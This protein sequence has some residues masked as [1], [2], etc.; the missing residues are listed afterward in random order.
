MYRFNSL[1]G[2]HFSVTLALSRLMYFCLLTVWAIAAS[3]ETTASWKS[4]VRA[5]PRTG[6]L[7]R[8]YDV[9]PAA[10]QSRQAARP[11]QVRELIEKTAAKHDV[12]PLLVDAVVQVES[13]YNPAAVSNKGAMGLMQLI[14]ATARRFGVSDPYDAQQNVEGGVKYLKHLQELYGDQRLALAAYNAGEGAV[15]RYGGTVPPYRE[16][17]EYVKEVDRRYQRARRANPPKAAEARPARIEQ[18]QDAEG[19]I[20]IELR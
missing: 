18:Y 17:Q 4:V 9:R 13:N 15:A 7:V 20:H 11:Q 12:D 1:K 8:T 16:T 14:P 10:G 5:D 19:R 3:A 2:N 6:R